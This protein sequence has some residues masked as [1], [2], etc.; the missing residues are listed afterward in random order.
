M[1]S[2]K[3]TRK[4]TGLTQEQAAKLCG[5]SRRTYQTYEENDSNQEKSN[6]LLELLKKAGLNEDGFP[7]IISVRFI[8]LTASEIFAKHP[9]V[10][11][12]YLFG[13]YARGEATPQSDV[14]FLIVEQGMSLLDMGGLLGELREALHKDVDLVTHRQILDNERMIRDVL[15]QGVKVYGHR[16][17]FF[18]N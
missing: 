15:R 10:E 9:E 4:Q 3:S 18:K 5:I 2:L 1:N 7:S 11:C 14:D 8:K 12:A 16:T 6:E 17:N 13:S